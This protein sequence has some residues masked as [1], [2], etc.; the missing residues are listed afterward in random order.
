[1]R[2][3]CRSF[4][5]GSLLLAALHGDA[6]AQ[7]PYQLRPLCRPVGPPVCQPVA[8]P[9]ACQPAPPS[10]A[11][12]PPRPVAPPSEVPPTAPAPKPEEAV[13]PAAPPPPAPPSPSAAVPPDLSSALAARE[14]AMG[15]EAPAP[16]GESLAM[17]NSAV[18]YIDPAIPG[19]Q[20]RLRFDAAYDS[21]RP[22]R[23]EFIYARGAPI[24]PGLPLPERRIDYQTVSSYVEYL[25]R[26]RLS[27]FVDIPV[28]FI[29][30]EINAD[31][32]GLGDLSTGIKYAFVQTPT[33]VATFQF[34]TY[35]PSGNAR[36]GL[37]TN[38]A[39]LEPGLLVYR[40]LAPRLRGEGELCF[41]VPAG[42]TSFSGDVIRYGA[43]LSYGARPPDAF[44]I[45]PVTEFVGWTVL[46]GKESFLPDGSLTPVVQSAS[47][48]TIL[49]AKVGVRAGVGNR[50]NV[51]AGY[52]RPLTGEVWYKN[53]WRLE[54]RLFY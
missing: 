42:G 28:R 53:L 51:Y 7:T 44:W 37:G 20:I 39:T 19:N 17:F 8:P 25:F 9:P 22:N 29:N 30:P 2:N 43:G 4:V 34:K 50:A 54:L 38:H 35:V 6:A 15:A 40:Q 47:G 10:A 46:G 52:G 33:S 12:A 13:P 48:D 26:P 32:G 3:R 11:P 27:G 24:G 1:M 21:N 49:N 36:L 5:L 14:P 31:A 41:W 23:A 45:S 18:G 16:E